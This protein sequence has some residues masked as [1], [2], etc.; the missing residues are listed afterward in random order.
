MPPEAAKSDSFVNG[1]RTYLES[2]A[3]PSAT[4]WNRSR[5]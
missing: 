5:A 4:I 2:E 1:R 3:T